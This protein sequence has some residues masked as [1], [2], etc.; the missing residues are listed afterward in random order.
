LPSDTTRKIAACP[1]VPQGKGGRYKT[2][3][4]QHSDEAV[5][6]R[7]GTFVGKSGGKPPYSKRPGLWRLS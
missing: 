1:F 6:R 7:H 4:G 2:I 3:G 5:K